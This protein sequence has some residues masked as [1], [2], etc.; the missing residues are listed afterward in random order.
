MRQWF[1]FLICLLGLVLP[2][3][4]RVLYANLLG[5]VTQGAYRFYQAVMRIIVEGLKK[6]EE[7]SHE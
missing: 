3:R 2:W 4:L 5:W 7:E 1:A 6:G